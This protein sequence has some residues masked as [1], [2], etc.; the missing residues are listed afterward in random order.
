MSV[1][2]FDAG[3]VALKNDAPRPAAIAGGQASDWVKKDILS[4]LRAKAEAAPV[5]EPIAFS[6]TD[7]ATAYGITVELAGA[8]IA[9][10]ERSLAIVA[11]VDGQLGTPAGYVL[12]K[13]S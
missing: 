1:K 9:S 4:R 13:A 10:L 7:V 3:R 11:R 2:L 8:I 12:G 6:A 5:A